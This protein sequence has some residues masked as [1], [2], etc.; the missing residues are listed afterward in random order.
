MCKENLC[1]RR[2]EEEEKKRNGVLRKIP[3]CVDKPRKI[4]LSGYNTSESTAAHELIY[5]TLSYS[6]GKC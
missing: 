4:L 2:E 6:N 3:L 5:A 1:F